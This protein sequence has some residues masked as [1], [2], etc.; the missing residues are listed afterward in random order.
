MYVSFIG[1]RHL[2]DCQIHSQMVQNVHAPKNK[3]L[4]IIF[5]LKSGHLFPHFLFFFL[6]GEIWKETPSKGPKGDRSWKCCFLNITDADGFVG[7]QFILSATA[8]W[9]YY[10]T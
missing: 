9:S 5:K 3:D 10:V 2:V 1:L 4:L 8:N 7:E 6:S